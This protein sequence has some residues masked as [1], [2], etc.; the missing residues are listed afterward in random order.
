MLFDEFLAYFFVIF[1]LTRWQFPKI[2]NLN[3]S[4]FFILWIFEVLFSCQFFLKFFSW[5][6][7][8]FF[9][10]AYSPPSKERKRSNDEAQPYVS[11]KHQKPD[12]YDIYGIKTGYR[13]RNSKSNSNQNSTSTRDISNTNPYQRT[14][15]D[16]SFNEFSGDE[17][18]NTNDRSVIV[19]D[20]TNIGGT[21]NYFRK[22]PNEIEI[23]QESVDP[24]D[25]QIKEEE[26]IGFEQEIKKKEVK[27]EAKP[28]IDYS[29]PLYPTWENGTPKQLCRYFLEGKCKAGD[30]CQFF[31]DLTKLEKRFELCKFYLH[32]VCS[33]GKDCT[34]MHETY[35]CK[36]YHILGKCYL[37]SKCKLSHT[38]LDTSDP[39]IKEVMT[40]LR[41][42]F[43][44]PS[45]KF[46]IEE[47]KRIGVEPL[48]KPPPGIGLLKLPPASHMLLSKPPSVNNKE[49]RKQNA[50]FRLD[51]VFWLM[52]RFFIVVSRV[53]SN[54]YGFENEF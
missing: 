45:D 23:K 39:A 48:E 54:K 40:R 18:S 2:L 22:N 1:I 28:V 29:D 27:Q 9:P 15:L 30:S 17:D 24:S 12:N 14:R 16:D 13:P 10:Q 32:G 38:K 8:S 43:H 49:L 6:F 44:M 4:K 25:I 36:Y 20:V 51:K 11:A 41:A 33:K 46:E 50:I 3:L 53:W 35:P 31:H 37:G 26:L 52:L 7:S 19:K 34:Y 42:T 47:M 21:S 5:Y